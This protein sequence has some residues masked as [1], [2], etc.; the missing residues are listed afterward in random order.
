MDTAPSAG[1]LQRRD[2]DGD[3]LR[4]ILRTADG[5]LLDVND[6]GIADAKQTEI[7]AIRLINDGSKASDYGYITSQHSLKF[8]SDQLIASEQL[9]ALFDIPTSDGATRT[10][11]PKR[12]NNHF[13]G[14]LS[15][16]VPSLNQEETAIIKLALAKDH[17]TQNA[18][19]LAY[20]T[21]DHQFKQFS[22]Y[23]NVDGKPLYSLIDDDKDGTI[24]KIELT[25]TEEASTAEPIKT[26]LLAEGNR[27]IKG[28]HENNVLKGNLLDNTVLGRNGDDKL[29]GS[30]GNDRLIGH[31]KNDLLKGGRGQDRLKGRSGNDQLKGGKGQDVLDGG[32]GND[33][34]TGGKGG[35]RFH[36][37]VGDDTIEDFSINDADQLLIKKTIDLTIEQIGNNLV[38]TNFDKGFSTTIKDVAS[39]DLL[40]HQPEL[41]G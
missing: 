4:E 5:K 15:F 19:N 32:K 23:Q 36:L 33:T 22:E 9:T 16:S 13:E 39:D 26:S 21:F 20:L 11:L 12:I 18:E 6:D 34:L 1:K 40:A 14:L 7:I 28:N 35:D 17:T 27:T 31:R 29:F 3:G 8:H 30:F 25:I 38:L 10:K 37:S 24:D 41:F 2:K